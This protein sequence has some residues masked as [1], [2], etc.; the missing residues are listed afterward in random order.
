MELRIVNKD[1][2]ELSDFCTW[3]LSLIQEDM[4]MS[5]PLEKL[6]IRDSKLNEAVTKTV[7]QTLLAR[8]VAKIGIHLL[9]WKKTGNYYTISFDTET[10]LAGTSN[11]VYELI[12]YLEYGGFGIQPLNFFRPIF[13]RY[14]NN[15]Q[16]YYELYL[17]LKGE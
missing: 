4:L 7:N 17:E 14:A 11:T 13:T 10:E 16:K 1:K 3:L 6:D 8:V 2:L 5:L 9:Y 15:L 12:K